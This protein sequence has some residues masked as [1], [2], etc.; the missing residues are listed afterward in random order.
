MYF[1][2]KVV[3]IIMRRFLTILLGALHYVF[4]SDGYEAVT[5]VTVKITVFWDV[6][7]LAVFQRNILPL[8]SGMKSKPSR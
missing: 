5:S 1:S 3:K 4:T 7:C 8:S 6:M 2:K